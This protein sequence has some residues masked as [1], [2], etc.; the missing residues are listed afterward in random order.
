MTPN[1]PTG[2]PALAPP[3]LQDK[4][5]VVSLQNLFPGSHWA[6]H[7]QGPGVAC[8]AASAPK[9]TCSIHF[10]QPEEPQLCRVPGQVLLWAEDHLT[11]STGWLRMA[12][13][14]T[15][16]WNQGTDARR[17]DTKSQVHPVIFSKKCMHLPDRRWES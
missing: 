15:P 2:F 1:L 11:I 5:R 4:E 7:P 17:R 9:A 10:P 12:V 3:S 14:S 8:V 16:T 6:T 13:F